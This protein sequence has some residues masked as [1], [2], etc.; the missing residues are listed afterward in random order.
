MEILMKILFNS[1][2]TVITDW[3]IYDWKRPLQISV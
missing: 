3:N 2:R 1:S